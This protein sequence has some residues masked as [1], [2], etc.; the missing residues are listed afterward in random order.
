MAG[1]VKVLLIPE[2]YNDKQSQYYDAEFNRMLMEEL[3]QM[4]KEE[5][6][7]ETANRP[8]RDMF[9]HYKSILLHMKEKNPLVFQ[10]FKQRGYQIIER[11]ELQFKQSRHSEDLPH[12]RVSLAMIDDRSAGQ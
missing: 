4:K 12:N 1:L 3:N 9:E 11:Q 5:E 10:Q 2:L 8:H 7:G 6:P